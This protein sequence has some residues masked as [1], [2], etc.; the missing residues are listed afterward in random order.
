M[1][2]RRVRASLVETNTLDTYYIMCIIICMLP[3]EIKNLRTA[4]GYT[5]RELA[6]K[7]GV[8]LPTIQNIEGGRANPSLSNIEKI[9]GALDARIEIKINLQSFDLLDLFNM[10]LERFKK[11]DLKELLLQFFKNANGTPFQGRELE[12]MVSLISGLIAH[13]P[14]WVKQQKFD[15]K[16]LK[17]WT[18]LENKFDPSRLIKF[19]RI[20]LAK[21]S[22]VI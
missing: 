19:R 5:Q 2:D 21:V 22:Q 12:L 4:Q 16:T 20:W 3:K 10:E 14:F 18:S 17:K 7:A 6:E 11:I 1:Q 13:Y 15:S 9:L 8:S